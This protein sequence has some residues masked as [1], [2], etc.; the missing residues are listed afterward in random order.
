MTAGSNVMSTHK[1]DELFSV[2]KPDNVIR[3]G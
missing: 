1:P 2:V 3:D